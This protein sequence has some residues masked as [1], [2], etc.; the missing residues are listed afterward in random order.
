[1]LTTVSIEIIYTIN[2]SL[3]QGCFYQLLF[4]TPGISP[5]LAASLKQIRHKPNLRIYPCFLPQE[6]QRRTTRD[7]N[8][9][10]F[11]DLAICACVAIILEL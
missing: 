1:M 4:F 3:Y 5:L 6:K 7:L 2:L 9:G 10:V 11:F 8:F